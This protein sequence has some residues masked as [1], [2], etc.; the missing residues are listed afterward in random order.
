M[1]EDRRV[2]VSSRRGGREFRDDFVAE[3]GGKGVRDANPEQGNE[4]FREL[5]F[6]RGTGCS[7]SEFCTEFAVRVSEFLLHVRREVGEPPSD[8]RKRVVRLGK[9]GKSCS[10]HVSSSSR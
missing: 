1:E 8:R 6:S 5:E 2:L 9:A 3:D 10:E 4:V 7:P